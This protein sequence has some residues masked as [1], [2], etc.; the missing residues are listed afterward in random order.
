M[1][2]AK[3][4]QRGIA[5]D[6]FQ[7]AGISWRK[8][9]V[10]PAGCLNGGLLSEFKL[11]DKVEKAKGYKWPG[12]VVAVFETL[13]GKKRYVVECAVPEVAGALHIYSAKDLKAYIGPIR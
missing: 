2:S 10:S 11:G 1:R 5:S 6:A 12:V 3:L 8:P 7:L 13:S 4:A 9:G